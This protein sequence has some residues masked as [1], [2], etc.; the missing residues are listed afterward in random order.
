M[1]YAVYGP[2]C[3]NVDVD[4]KLSWECH[5]KSIKSR[6]SRVIRNLARTASVLPLKSRR[7]LY[8]ALVTPHFSYCDTVWGG[9]SGK[10]KDDLQKVG[11]FAAKSMLG[12]K[13][14]DS[15]TEALLKL[16]MMPLEDK[17]TVHLAVFTHK[18]VNNIGPAQLVEDY[19][20]LRESR[21]NHF[22][23]MT[24]RG[25]MKSLQHKTDRFER[26][27]LQRAIKTWNNIPVEIRKIDSTSSFKRSFQ[28]HLLTKFKENART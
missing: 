5:I 27:T 1:V 2:P 12:M 24:T 11:N 10:L 4:E 7:Q 13:K 9:L 16:S 21:H 8:D 18:L 22:T 3:T 15:A 26:S 17:R 25:D 28:A 23:R 19:K 14:R 20:S 6:T